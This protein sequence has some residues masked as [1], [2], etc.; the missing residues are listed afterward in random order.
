M[1]RETINP[2]SLFDSRQYGFSQ[3][4]VS[5]PGKMIF[6]SGQVAWDEE[7]NIVGENDL[8]KQTQKSL[9]NLE[10]AIKAAGGTLENIVMLRIY[11]V[12]YQ[13]EDGAIINQILKGNFGTINPPASSWISVKGL[14]NEKFM[15]EIEAQAVI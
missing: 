11:I 6:I 12:N 7:L 4:V 13:K 1:K 15:I 9:D 2:K 10:I 8:A 14:A 5:N 3:I